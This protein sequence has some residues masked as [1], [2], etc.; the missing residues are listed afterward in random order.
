MRVYLLIFKGRLFTPS[1]VEHVA[2][3]G[4]FDL[5]GVGGVG[6]RKAGSTTQWLSSQTRFW[7]I[8]ASLWI[9]A[10]T[11]LRALPEWL[12]FP[13]PL[14]RLS[15]LGS[16]CDALEIP[17]DDVADVNDPAL[18]RKLEGLDLDVIVCFQQ[19]IFGAELLALPRLGCLNVHTGVLPGYR[20]FKPVF[21]MHSRGEERLGV[22]VHTMTGQID[23]GRVVAQR[24][25][26]RRP[27]SSVLENQLWSYR[28]AAHTI[29]EAVEKLPRVA[30]ADLPTISLESPYFK[31]PTR[32]ERDAAIAAGTRLL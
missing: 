4:D 20:G 27:Q 32:A 5:V 15:S 30:I 18:R 1:I 11:L 10:A 26:R 7:G 31:A 28:C 25:W 6:G 19:Q 16:T 22:T 21:W 12:G 2:V 14:R 13:R 29:I 9:G 8:W 17:Y 3:S 23:V 24:G